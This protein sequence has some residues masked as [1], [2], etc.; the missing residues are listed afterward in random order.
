[1]DSC[2]ICSNADCRFIVDLHELPR[3]ELIID[4]CP[5]CGHSWSSSCPFCGRPL[6][7]ILRD[8]LLHCSH[9]WSGAAGGRCHVTTIRREK[10]PGAPCFGL[11]ANRAGSS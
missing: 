3:S 2:L 6:E 10:Q 9:L 1:M 8:N 7:T 5:E 4:G 11:S